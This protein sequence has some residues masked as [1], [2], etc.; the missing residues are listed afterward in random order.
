MPFLSKKQVLFVGGGLL[1][2]LII[3][4]VFIFSLREEKTAKRVNLEVWGTEDDDVFSAMARSYSDLRTNVSIDYTQISESSFET[5]L[6]SALASGKGPDVFFVK[7]HSLPVDLISPAPETQFT[8]ESMKSLFPKVIEQDFAP[9][10]IVY[11]LPLYLDTLALVY[12]QNIYNRAGIVDPPTDWESFEDIVSDLKVL[13]DNGRIKKAGAAIGGSD[14]SISNGSEIL[15]MLILQNGAQ[16]IDVGARGGAT[17]AEGTRGISAFD[18]YTKFGN[19]SDTYFT[20][21]DSG[22]NSMDSFAGEETVMLLTYKSKINELKAKNPF[23]EIGVA[24]IPQVSAENPITFADYFGLAVSKQSKEQSWAWDFIINSA[25]Q[26]DIARAYHKASGRPPALK[27]LI[28]ENLKNAEY[29]IFARQA[30]IAKSWY[31]ADHKKIKEILS[32]AIQKKILG[33]ADSK[34]AL[35]Q[36]QNQISE[37]ISERKDD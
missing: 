9:G 1:V 22:K 32:Q 20:W 14:R 25:T 15:Q 12:N 29:G 27:A 5:R 34:T 30:L 18:F 8:L 11:A 23:L 13:D 31:F 26:P 2:L 35:T 37:I 21:D 36:A 16:M 4:V 33:A 28:S 3:G 6:I 24:S 7:S 10:G 19:P 17:F